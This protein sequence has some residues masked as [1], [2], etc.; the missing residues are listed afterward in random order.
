MLIGRDGLPH[1]WIDVPRPPPAEWPVA[2]PRAAGSLAEA[3]EQGFV[4]RLVGLSRDADGVYA[5]YRK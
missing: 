5:I 4:F 1:L 2:D 3:P